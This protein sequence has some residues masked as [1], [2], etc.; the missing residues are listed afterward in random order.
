MH[1]YP[2]TNQL[3]IINYFDKISGFYLNKNNNNSNK[4]TTYY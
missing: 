3:F 1:Y 4:N 2:T